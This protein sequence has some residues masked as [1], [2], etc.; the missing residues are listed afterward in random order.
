[1]KVPTSEHKHQL[2]LKHT[3]Y[4]FI[5]SLAKEVNGQSVVN[6]NELWEL[7]TFDRSKVEDVISDFSSSGIWMR[8]NEEIIIFN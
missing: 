2:S 1:M 3:I 4:N 6:L 7:C 8:N 5:I